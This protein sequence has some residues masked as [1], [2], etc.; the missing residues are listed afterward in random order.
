VT[1]TVEPNTGVKIVNP[2][3]QT[4]RV[5]DEV[6]L[7]IRVTGE[8]AAHRHGVFTAAGLPSGLEMKDD[9]VIRGELRTVGTSRVTV[10]FR[11]K[12][13]A[14]STHFDWTVL[15]RSKKGGKD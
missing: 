2:G 1:I 14:V 11:L 9:G 13:V 6:R 8:S 4:D 10:T 7:R 5:G 3:P 12:G 15:P